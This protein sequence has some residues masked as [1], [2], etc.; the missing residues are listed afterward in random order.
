MSIN[1]RKTIIP[2]LGI[3]TLRGN[4]RLIG[5]PKEYIQVII[6]LPNILEFNDSLNDSIEFFKE[7]AECIIITSSSIE[8][9]KMILDKYNLSNSLVSRQYKDFANI[10][11]VQDENNNLKKSLMIVNKNCEITHKNI[12]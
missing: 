7:K 8:E 10:F 4:T 1:L 6:S 9:C 11:S 2:A 12:L 5:I 3:K